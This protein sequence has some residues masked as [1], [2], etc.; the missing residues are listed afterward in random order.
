MW[1]EVQPIKM[2]VRPIPTSENSMRILLKSVFL[3]IILSIFT[4]MR[5]E[6]TTVFSTQ[7]IQTEIAPL[8]ARIKNIDWNM[9]TLYEEYDTLNITLHLTIVYF[10]VELEIWNPDIESQ[11]IEFSDSEEFPLTIQE[12]LEESY[13]DLTPFWGSLPVITPR[14]YLL[15]ITTKSYE[16]PFSIIE[17]YLTQLPNGEYRIDLKPPYYSNF[18]TSIVT[19]GLSLTVTED[20]EII[21]YDPFPYENTD[22]QLSYIVSECDCDG[23]SGWNEG[24]VNVTIENHSIYFEQVFVTWCNFDKNNLTIKLAQ[25][26]ETLMILEEYT[27]T[28]MTK[29]VCAYQIF[30]QITNLSVGNY[31]LV[32]QYQTTVVN[33]TQSRFTSA[34]PVLLTE[35]GPEYDIVNSWGII[36]SF[37]SLFF[38]KKKS[39]RIRRN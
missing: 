7:N 9:T 32:F 13:L 34:I 3:L 38:A 25:V 10:K 35:S 1:Q 26:G 21:E 6:T 12:D 8:F 18:D 14:T 28:S 23:S 36:I 37:L 22:A 5:T 15:G 27:T 33:T 16:Y 11:T 2:E 31:T 17:P 30:G 4:Q 39:S 20:T 29:C 24:N 19:Y